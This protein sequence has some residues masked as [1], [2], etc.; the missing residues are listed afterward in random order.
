MATC[1]DKFSENP[2]WVLLNEEDDSFSIRNAELWLCVT[3]WKRR[4]KTAFE[5]HRVNSLC[6]N[7]GTQSLGLCVKIGNAGLRPR[8]GNIELILFV[9]IGNTEF[10]AL[11]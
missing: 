5:E 8:L 6:Q 2:R 7:L 11:C 1:F 9:E 10:R 4:L 3:N